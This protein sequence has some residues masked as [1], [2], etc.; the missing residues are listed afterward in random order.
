MVKFHSD[1]C[2]SSIEEL[3]RSWSLDPS[4]RFLNHGSYGAVPKVILDA[5]RQLEDQIERDPVEFMMEAYPERLAHARQSLASFV[6]ASPERLAFIRNATEG[7]NALFKSL[8][9]RDN[10]EVLVSSHGYNACI[11][12]V[13]H[14]AATR[15]FKV[16][17]W[18]LPWPTPTDE[19]IEHSLLESI[20]EHTKVVV[21]DHITSPTALRLPIERLIA[22]LRKRGITTVVDG[23]HGPG[24]EDLSLD[25][26]GADYYIGNLHKWLCN[27]RGTA[28]LYR[29]NPEE[30]P[31]YPV[32][33]SHGSSAWVKPR[34]NR[35]CESFDWAGTQNPSSWCTVPE[36]IA[37]F[38]NQR[39][40][41]KTSFIEN[42]RQRAATVAH[43][44]QD[45]P[46][47]QTRLT[48]AQRLAMVLLE[49]KPQSATFIPTLPNQKSP[50]QKQ[51]YDG[52]RVQVPVLF[53]EGRVYLRISIHGYVREDDIQTLDRAI[54]ELNRNGVLSTW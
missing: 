6:G 28:F 37:W 8:P 27:P 9:L 17:D 21:V 13:R 20:S 2:S 18:M 46:L 50:L 44:F 35:F 15:G 45:H 54:E 4:I 24:Q 36:T 52:W 38:E 53:I 31:I 22:L 34:L 32:V 43:H 42:N 41:S 19:S 7:I 5:Q 39:P 49:I 10:D 25:S 29:L 23:A 12:A 3:R 47:A 30:P 40:D 11:E 33:I 16:V 1:W 26:L 48:S 14:C 51:L